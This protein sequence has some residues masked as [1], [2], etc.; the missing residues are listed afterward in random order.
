[1]PKASTI[2]EQNAVEVPL[3][4]VMDV[5]RYLRLP[6]WAALAFSERGRI[7][8]EELF[9]QLMHRPFSSASFADD[10]GF[11]RREGGNRRVSF[12]ALATLFVRSF[13][14][15]LPQSQDRITAWSFEAAWEAFRFP[16]GEPSLFAD[17]DPDRIVNHF[18]RNGPWIAGRNHDEAVKL[19][20]LCLDRVEL[21][22]NIPVRL[23][24]FSRDPSPDAP[25][26]VVIDPEV[27]FGRPTVKG[28]PTDV[29]AERW[30]AGDSPE[31]LA[32]D[33]DLT[34]D[35]VNES[36]RYESMP[37][38]LPFPFFGW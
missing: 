9:H 29:L 31:S 33:Y 16:E 25:R 3:Y 2:A 13:L 26:F 4:T 19:V 5:A 8:P 10:S 28:A 37:S 12:R 6:T 7:H 35:E 22:D 24:P 17:P 32:E 34:T 11:P 21:K 36:L 1:M 27:R 38:R 14:F 30:R 18:E 23:F 20:A 15:H